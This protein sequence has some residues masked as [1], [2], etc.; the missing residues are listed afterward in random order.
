MKSPFSSFGFSNFISQY[1][2]WVILGLSIIILG[3][4]TLFA[5]WPKVNTLR[6]QGFDRKDTREQTLQ[7]LEKNL[8]SLVSAKEQY[9]AISA[10]DLLRLERTLPTKKEVAKLITEIPVFA[11]AAGFSPGDISLSESPFSATGA[12]ASPS[13]ARLHRI[14]ISLSVGGIDSYDRFKDFLSQLEDSI[15]VLEL[16]SIT[17]SPGTETYA[18]VLRTYYTTLAAPSS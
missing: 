4:G 5:I 15:K 11:A 12:K 1:H 16:S 14:D 10:E 17:Y 9:D 2:L 18:F 7:Q 3:A 13:T 8:A 6:E